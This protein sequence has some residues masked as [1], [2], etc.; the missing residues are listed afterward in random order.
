MVITQNYYQTVITLKII[1]KKKN[2]PNKIIIVEFEK[3]KSKKPNLIA[4]TG[5]I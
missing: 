2:K 1:C 3:L 5:K 4:Q